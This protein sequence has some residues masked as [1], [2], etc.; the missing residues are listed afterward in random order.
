MRKTLM[1]A[2][3]AALTL[4]VAMTAG[5]QDHPQSIRQV[6]QSVLPASIKSM[7]SQDSK[8]TS[9]DEVLYSKGT[10]QYRIHYTTATGENKIM[11]AG[12]ATETTPTGVFEHATGY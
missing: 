2:T 3:L 7:F 10:R 4:A 6:D 8:I 5:C 12:D 9:V 11:N 1:S